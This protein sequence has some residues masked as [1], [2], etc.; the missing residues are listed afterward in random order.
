MLYHH[1]ILSEAL[2]HAVKMGLVARNAAAVVDPPR[3][4]GK[5][6]TALSPDEIDRFLE[7]ARQTDHYV[8]F[9]SLLCTGLRRGE[10]LAL[11]WRNLDLE[12]AVLYVL[13]TAFKLGNGEYVIKEPKTP[14]SRRAVSLPVSLLSLLLAY[15]ADQE[16]KG[17]ILGGDDF[18]FSGYDGAP[19]SPNAVTLAF[20]RIIKKA[21]LNHLRVHDLRHTHAT[22]MLKAGVHPKV[23]SERLGHA[24]VG[25]T[26]DTYS[27]VLPGLQEVAVEKFDEVLALAG[28]KLG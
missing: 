19:L 10:L 6:M 20:R 5:K 11:R 23:V 3:P 28:K 26:L 25:I 8:F 22:L 13:E 18:V 15:R 9:A 16:K 4:V 12:R 2:G 7:A 21:K 14:H 1:R 17:A 24:S 27:H